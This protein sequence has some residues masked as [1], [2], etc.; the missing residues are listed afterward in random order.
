[1]MER[2]KRWA[3]TNPEKA[4]AN[5]ARYKKRYPARINA[6]G[7]ARRSMRLKATPPWLTAIQRAQIAEFYEIATARSVQTGI[8]HHVDHIHPL[9]GENFRGL[10][11]PWN[12]QVITGTENSR[13]KNHL[14]VGEP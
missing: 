1:M 10:H 14:I 8:E 12:L 3:Q 7:A 2:V 11:V 9:C 4:R 13:K 6:E 5:K